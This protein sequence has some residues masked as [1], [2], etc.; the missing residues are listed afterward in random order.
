MGDT[1]IGIPAQEQ[2][3]LFTRFFRS[4]TARERAIQGTGLGLSIVQSIVRSHGGE[5]YVQ[6]EHLV[7]TRV[8][9]QPCW[10]RRP[11]RPGRGTLTRETLRARREP[12]G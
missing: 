9:V 12:L 5:I 8:L 7:G 10:S 11:F 3:A 2:A 4:T 1:G 6:S